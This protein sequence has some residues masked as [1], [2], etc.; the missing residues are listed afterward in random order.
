V[1]CSGSIIARVDVPDRVYLLD[2]QYGRFDI[3]IWGLELLKERLARGR[4]CSCSVRIWEAEIVR[5]IGL[6]Q[7]DQDTVLMFEQNAR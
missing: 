1:T 4:G 7:R 5:A 6:T 2:G 3:D